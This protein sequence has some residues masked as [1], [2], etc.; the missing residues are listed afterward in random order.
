MAGNE[1]DTVD[2]YGEPASEIGDNKI[3]TIFLQQVLEVESKTCAAEMRNQGG[4]LT[5]C[6]FR[7]LATEDDALAQTPPVGFHMVFRF[8]G[9]IFYLGCRLF[10]ASGMF[11]FVSTQQHV[12]LRC[13][14]SSASSIS[15]E[16]PP[17]ARSQP[18]P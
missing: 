9:D 1:F 2:G 18:S 4:K 15:G 10:Q 3:R 14:S 13:N 17:P 5:P 11:V 16:T 6:I 7:C 12:T 8:H